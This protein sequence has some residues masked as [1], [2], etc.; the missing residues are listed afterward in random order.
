MHDFK[1]LEDSKHMFE[2]FSGEPFEQILL[3]AHHVLNEIAEVIESNN[4]PGLFL[5]DQPHGVSLGL[6]TSRF[7]NRG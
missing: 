2:W 1:N 5:G 3:D 7:K 6:C 4:G